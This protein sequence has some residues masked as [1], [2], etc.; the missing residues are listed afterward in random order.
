M[1]ISTNAYIEQNRVR[2]SLI[3]ILA[4]LTGT[5]SSIYLN[6]VGLIYASEL[7]IPVVAIIAFLTS[8]RIDLIKNYYLLL[9]VLF[10]FI[11]FSGYIVSDLIAE[12]DPSRYQRGWARLGFLLSNVIAFVMLALHSKNNIWWYL[13]GTGMGTVI[14]KL[15]SGVPI[16]TWKLGYG[17][18]LS[19]IVICTAFLIPKKLGI[20][21]IA[22]LGMLSVFL[23]S[24]VHGA[25]ILLVAVIMWSRMGGMETLGQYKSLFKLLLAGVVAAMAIWYILDATAEDYSD[26][27]SES[28]DGREA[29][30]LVGIQAIIQSPLVGYGSWTVNKELADMLREHL[31]ELRGPGAVDEFDERSFSEG[32]SPHS[33]ILQVW[34]EGGIFGAIFFLFFAYMLIK[35]SYWHIMH[36]PLDVYSPVFLYLLVQGLWH[37]LASH[38]GGDAR[39]HIAVALSIAIVSMV[40]KGRKN[41]DSDSNIEEVKDNT[42]T[43]SNLD[44][45]GVLQRKAS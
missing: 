30:I 34:V 25:T 45:Y 35:A 9:A 10:I 22:A 21:F 40:E 29:G 42:K 16:L 12:T 37:L 36:R 8:Q 23:D 44:P 24:R 3:S 1:N 26:R 32:F 6:L 19:F 20:L 33:M 14:I 7:A 2:V 28:N 15:A 31:R 4:F 38:F 18:P 39:I 41:I 13:L 5:V 43:K 11:S 17:A 27:R